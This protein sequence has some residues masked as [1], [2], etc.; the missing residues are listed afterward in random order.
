MQCGIRSGFCANSAPHH[1]R[2]SFMRTAAGV[3]VKLT[4]P[5]NW[6]AKCGAMCRI[7]SYGCEYPYHKKS[8]AAFWC[9]CGAI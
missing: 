8:S 4:T 3:C 5:Q 6:F 2:T 7:V 1:N 9:G